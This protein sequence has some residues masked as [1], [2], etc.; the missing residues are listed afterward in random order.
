MLLSRKRKSWVIYM[1]WLNKIPNWIRIPIKILLP[2][3]TIFSGILLFSGDNVIEALYMSDFKEKK[4][5][6]FRFDFYNYIVFR[7][8]ICFLLFT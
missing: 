4:W 2:A 7:N 3:L 8:C 5:F 1:E 6:F